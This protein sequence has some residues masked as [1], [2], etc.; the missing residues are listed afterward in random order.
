MQYRKVKLFD[1]AVH[2][3]PRLDF[4]S[5]KDAID[6]IDSIFGTID[7]PFINICM[8]DIGFLVTNLMFENGCVYGDVL[9]L[10]TI[11]GRKIKKLFENLGLNINGAF[12]MHTHGFDHPSNGRKIEELRFS[13]SS[14]LVRR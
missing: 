12:V 3:A 10:D 9:V 4:E 11:P 14:E 6:C 2:D 7:L 13:V 5:L 1:S 8:S